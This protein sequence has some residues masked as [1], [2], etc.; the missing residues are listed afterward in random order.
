MMK[1]PKKRQQQ[2]F[3]HALRSPRCETP[4]LELPPADVGDSLPRTT[5]GLAVCALAARRWIKRG[6][7]S[8]TRI[9]VARALRVWRNAGPEEQALHFDIPGLP[10]QVYLF[11]GNSDRALAWVEH[12]EHWAEARQ[13]VPALVSAWCRHAFVALHRGDHR[14]ALTYA[15]RAAILCEWKLKSASGLA[16]CRL[17]EG[18]AL[19]SR[20]LH[21]SARERLTEAAEAALHADE[22]LLYTA[23]TQGLGIVLMRMG[24]H[25]RAE[26][27]FETAKEIAERCGDR[28]RATNAKLGLALVA[29]RTGR[30]EHLDVLRA[31]ASLQE[32]ITVSQR[33]LVLECEA[34]LLELSGVR[35]SEVLKRY[36]HAMRAARRLNSPDFVLE[37]H[38]RL[39]EFWLGR[40]VHRYARIHVNRAS[41]IEGGLPEDRLALQR[42]E[43]ECRRLNGEDMLDA[44][45]AH[46]SKAATLRYRYEEL[47]TAHQVAAAA[48]ARDDSALIR[49]WWTRTEA[50]AE[51]C[52]A[53]GLFRRWCEENRDAQG[54]DTGSG[55]V[56]L[57]LY[58][59]VTHS[60]KLESAAQQVARVAPSTVPILVRGETGS[61]KELLARLA[62]EASHRSGP[63]QAV[64]CAAIPENL[65]ESELFGHTRGAFTGAV[66][67]RPGIFQACSGGTL[68]LDEIGDMP[69]HLQAKL[70]RVLETGEVR[71]V[72][73]LTPEKV[74][75]RLVTATHVDLEQA[76]E[77]GEFRRDLFYRI[78]GLE[79]WVPSLAQ[80]VQ[81]IGLLAEHFLQQVA[82]QSGRDLF[83][84]K[85]SADL[86][87][88]RQWPG[89]VRE[90][91]LN[92]ERAA[93]LCRGSLVL[94]HHFEL[95]GSTAPPASLAEEL[96][97]F[98]RSR[99]ESALEKTGGNV[100]AAAVLLGLSRTT[101]HG[102]MDR[103][104][105]RRPPR[106]A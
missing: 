72:G 23:A 4:L 74:D 54:D 21:Q 75:V 43:L 26:A 68:F 11:Q 97:A 34:G 15:R 100:A 42:L 84:S 45:A 7:G 50:L 35:P 2:N 13:C 12:L 88:R 24:D 8:Q 36:Q 67:N 41:A 6:A 102:K 39:A 46:A 58:G 93:A 30:P 57:R 59:I 5:D 22:L 96:E 64:N 1:Q 49:T 60:K 31:D 77:R 81:D 17:V 80:R 71:K 76:I 48:E 78:R 9:A 94:P 103:L 83:L 18:F 20:G 85:E 44:L 16:L 69:K 40:Q 37:L 92:I 53:Q 32:N 52:N 105:V 56:D 61:G 47:L 98:E 87:T 3:N 70:L 65:I 104:G 33:C 27:A 73:S 62:H 95:N 106:R 91:K 89:N 66:Q 25:R 99:I 55:Q 10:A 51:R 28:V 29:V 63:F 86:L 82:R 38:R 14:E 101:V 19:K 79:V 90:L